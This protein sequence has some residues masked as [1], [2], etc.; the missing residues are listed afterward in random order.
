MQR[1]AK[2]RVLARDVMDEVNLSKITAPDFTVSVRAG[3]PSLVVVDE[4][5]IPETFFEP[6]P[7]KLNRQALMEELKGGATI[8]GALLEQAESTLTVRPR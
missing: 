6:R 7:P 4:R 3:V 8:A 1:A 5:Q 2:R